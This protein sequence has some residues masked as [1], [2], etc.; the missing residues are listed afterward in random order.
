M[1]YNIL[2]HKFTSRLAEE[3]SYHH[4]EVYSNSIDYLYRYNRILREIDSRPSLIG[5]QEVDHY[6]DFWQPN[7]QKQG[8]DVRIHQN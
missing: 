2:A 7:L 1:S 5:L 6:Q 3:R 8:Y 4:I